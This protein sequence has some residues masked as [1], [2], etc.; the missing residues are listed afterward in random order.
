M[1][2]LLHITKRWV[3]SYFHVF[4]ELGYGILHQ[5]YL[6]NRTRMRMTEVEEPKGFTR[7]QAWV[8][9][10]PAQ[11]FVSLILVFESR[12]SAGSDA[13]TLVLVLP[14]NVWM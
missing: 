8:Y 4:R 12:N 5:V 3:P 6:S 7:L 14:D 13:S 10:Q 9:L 11:S 2:N 1:H